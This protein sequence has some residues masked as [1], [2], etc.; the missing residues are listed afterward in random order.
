MV[1]GGF[2]SQIFMWNFEPTIKTQNQQIA[3]LNTSP[4]LIHS[5]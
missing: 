4:N 3:L 2:G 5:L 1:V